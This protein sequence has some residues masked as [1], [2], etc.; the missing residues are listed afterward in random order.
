MLKLIH[1]FQVSRFKV[2]TAKWIA[3]VIILSITMLIGILLAL[4]YLFAAKNIVL[5][6]VHI[7]R[8]LLLFFV[9]FLYV[10]CFYQV[11][12]FISC[13]VNSSQMSIVIMFFVW[14]ITL[15]ITPNISVLLGKQ[16]S[17]IPPMDYISGEDREISKQFDE[18]KSEAFKKNYND[19]EDIQQNEKNAAWQVHQDYLNNLKKQ[20]RMAVKFSI[21]SPAPFFDFAAELLTGTSVADYE[22]FMGRVR[23]INNEYTQIL[24]KFIR[25]EKTFPDYKNYIE[26]SCNILSNESLK[27]IRLPLGRSIASCVSFYCMDSSVGRNSLFPDSYILS[28]QNHIILKQRL[29]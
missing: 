22:N 18:L 13:L 23:F 12:L 17:P 3:G 28:S 27:D 24:L 6:Q 11:S 26:E 4:L 29:L 8:L 5:E 21:I 7:I 19:I 2:V 9:S 1:S 14:A 15:F 25:G 16:F 10:L 20:C